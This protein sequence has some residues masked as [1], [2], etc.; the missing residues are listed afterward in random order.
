M[1]GLIVH[2]WIEP[3][4]GAENVVAEFAARFPEAPIVCAW[5]DT[6]DR[7]APGRTI[8]TWLARTPLRHSKVAALPFML[9]TWRHLPGRE[10]D[11]LLCSSHLFAH[12]AR[13][14]SAPDVP[15][16]AFVHTPARYLWVPELDGRGDSFAARLASRPLT[17]IDRRRAQE[18]TGIAAVS[19][20]IARR[21][22]TTWGRE[23]T[24][25]HPPVNIA[26]FAAP[27]SLTEADAIVAS[28]LPGAFVLGASRLVPYKRVDAAIMAGEAARLPV[29]IAG[30]GPD[31][32]R[33][34]ALAERA[35]VPVT[36]LGRTSDALLRELYRRATV[37]VFAPV[38][39]FGIMPVEAMAAGTPVVARDI[40]GASE[41]VVD[42][43]T[44]A[45]VSGLGAAQ[46][47]EAVRRAAEASPHDCRAR[48]ATFDGR[49][50]GA[51]V[52]TWMAGL[53]ADV[54]AGDPSS[55]TR[56]RGVSD[57]EH[58]PP[59]AS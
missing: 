16:F 5:D 35:R 24:V 50:F 9:P 33:L 44:G 59:D 12:H 36:L 43:V 47:G 21:I 58:L 37:Y 49:T 20:Y 39:D 7:F 32:P 2:E 54:S 29:V 3:H 51:R 13:V 25:I 6:D 14:A 55:D 52:A 22:E 53:G 19:E 42:G 27:P 15:K 41:T 4:G 31:R 56:G 28:S 11:W 26:A 30:D 17:R 18:P 40:G 48:A 45:L 38:E 34:A 46:L 23:S 10:P 8:E 1:T 57:G